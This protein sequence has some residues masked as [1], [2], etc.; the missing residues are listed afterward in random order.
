MNFLEKIKIELAKEI[1]K[2]LGG[3]N[4]AVS[5][6][7]YPPEGIGGDLSLPCFNLAKEN[8]KSPVELAKEISEKIKIGKN[9]AKVEPVGP[10]VNFFLDQTKISKIVLEQIL[11]EKE[12]YGEGKIGKNQKVMIEFSN[13]NTHKEYHVGHLRNLCYGDAVNRILSASGYKSIPVSYINDFGIHVAKTLWAYDKFYAKEKIPNNKGHFLGEIYARAVKEIG[14]SEESKKEV[15]GLMR[16]IESRKGKEYKLWQKTRQW[17]IKQFSSIYKELGVKFDQIFYE[18]EV[19][20]E[21][22]EMVDDLIKKNVLIKSQGAIIADLEKYGLGVLMFLRSDGTAL[23]PVADIPLAIKKFKKYKL[24]KSIYVVDVRQGLYFKQLFKVLNQLGFKQEMI[25]L[26]YEFVKLSSGMMSSRTGNVITYETLWEEAMERAKSETKIRHENWSE[27]QIEAVAEKIVI[28]AI[29]F[30]M[31]KVGKEK[32]ITFDANEALRFEGFTAAYIQYTYARISSIIRKA[33]AAKKIQFSKIE[34]GNL[35][36]I[37][38]HKLSIALAKFSEAIEKA[39]ASYNPATLAE[40]LYSLAKCFN[41]FYRDVPVLKADNEVRLARVAL[42]EATR[43]VLENGLNLLGIE[44][45]E[46]M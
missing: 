9:V 46:R 40:Y 42:L 11:K 27:K 16:K 10:Y 30:E 15:G 43:I 39:S 37:S 7:E 13:A 23:Y 26:G 6:F 29:K 31:I 41:D 24:D 35:K 22:R 34:F 2:I 3:E 4:I 20:D 1:N 33:G 14:D 5:D 12:K 17:S 28:G 44:A 45:P 8:K 19:I 36:E 32:I 18:S 21:G 38:E 25:H